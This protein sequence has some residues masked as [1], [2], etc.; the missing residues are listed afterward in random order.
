M[1]LTEKWWL[2]VFIVPIAVFSSL[3]IAAQV[4]NP[5][6]PLATPQ[7]EGFSQEGLRRIDAFF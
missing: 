5:P 4:R 7:S 2:R 1:Q 6:L 3:S